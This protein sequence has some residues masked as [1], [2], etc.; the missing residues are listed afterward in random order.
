M[1]QGSGGQSGRNRGAEKGYFGTID[2]EGSIALGL[3]SS[4]GPF[5]FDSLFMI[6]SAH[7]LGG[8]K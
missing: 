4:E 7:F 8:V 6:E 5:I 3:S 1:K 2:D